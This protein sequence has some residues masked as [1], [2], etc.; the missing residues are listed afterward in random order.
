MKNF[1]KSFFDY[2]D[3]SHRI[4][5]LILSLCAVGLL[6]ASFLTPPMGVIDGSVIAAVGELFAFSA[7]GTFLDAIHLNKK[8]SVRKGSL[9][10]SIDGKNE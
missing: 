4:W 8:A 2:L 9:E 5:F 1:I 7:L 6:I 10:I 3:Q